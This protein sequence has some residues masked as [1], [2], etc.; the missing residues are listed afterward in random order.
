M[1]KYPAAHNRERDPSRSGHLG[2]AFFRNEK[3]QLRRM[4]AMGDVVIV[5]VVVDVD[6]FC[7]LPWR[8]KV[9]WYEREESRVGG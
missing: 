5:V 1:N 4:R 8:G 6:V 2:D 9:G 7:C 3:L